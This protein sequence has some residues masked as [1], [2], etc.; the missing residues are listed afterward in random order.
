MIK[1]RKKYTPQEFIQIGM[2]LFLIGVCMSM[3]ANGR[4]IEIFFAGL[5]TDQSTMDA[6]QGIATG[7]SI[8]ISC[9][10]IFFNVRGLVLLRSQ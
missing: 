2:T 4:L 3:I 7:I 10:S 6:I 1:G 8:P 5:I 9:V